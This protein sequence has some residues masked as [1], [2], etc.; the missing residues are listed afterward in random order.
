MTACV[1]P[2]SRRQLFSGI[3]VL[4]GRVWKNM[5]IGQARMSVRVEVNEVGISYINEPGNSGSNV[6]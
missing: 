3:G 2:M 6:W 1:D 4:H 5:L